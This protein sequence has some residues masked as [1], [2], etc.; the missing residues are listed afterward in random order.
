MNENNPIIFAFAIWTVILENKFSASLKCPQFTHQRSLP[1][2]PKSSSSH[3]D[4][5]ADVRRDPRFLEFHFRRFRPRRR[6]GHRPQSGRDRREQFFGTF[7]K[8]FLGSSHEQRSLA[9]VLSSIDCPAVQVG[10][11]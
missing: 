2:R 11:T 10:L 1:T 3:R 5:F 4:A 7:F 6:R 8:R 9:Q